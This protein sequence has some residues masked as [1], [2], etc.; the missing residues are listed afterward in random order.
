MLFGTPPR[1]LSQKTDPQNLAGLGKRLSLNR[2]TSQVQDQEEHAPGDKIKMPKRSADELCVNITKEIGLLN[3]RVALWTSFGSE[4]LRLYENGSLD[5]IKQKYPL[6]LDDLEKMGYKRDCLKR[7]N[8]LD[9]RQTMDDMSW[10]LTSSRKQYQREEPSLASASY[11]RKSANHMEEEYRLKDSFKPS[12]RIL[13]IQEL[14]GDYNIQSI[15]TKQI[16]T[17]KKEA[18]P[19]LTFTS[20][21]PALSSLPTPKP[22]LS[23]LN[24]ATRLDTADL[25]YIACLTF[26]YPKVADREARIDNLNTANLWR[27]LP[28][29]KIKEKIHQALDF[30]KE[31][32]KSSDIVDLSLELSVDKVKNALICFSYLH[33]KEHETAQFAEFR[34]LLCS[35]IKQTNPGKAGTVNKRR[36]F[37][38]A[39]YYAFGPVHLPYLREWG[40]VNTELKN[41]SE[42]M[43]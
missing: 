42:D 18:S 22:V 10:N 12:D 29:Y 14:E 40:V 36:R 9:L 17:S 6:L 7:Q 32:S 43:C 13:K 37:R 19:A 33:S 25:D 31:A 15:S 24:T 11:S 4:M 26:L 35:V 27:E 16:K 30:L 23:C 3:T 1:G 41:G 8:S 34:D 20:I 5:R 2:H 39:I 38:D 21:L 28:P